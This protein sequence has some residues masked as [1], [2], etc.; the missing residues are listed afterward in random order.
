MGRP[1]LRTLRGAMPTSCMLSTSGRDFLLM[2]QLQVLK[3]A[4]QQKRHLVINQHNQDP[5]QQR[6]HQS[7][8]V[9][10]RCLLT[11]V[12][13]LDRQSLIWLVS[14]VELAATQRVGLSTRKTQHSSTMPSMLLT[15]LKLG[16]SPPLLMTLWGRW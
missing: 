1:L 15:S 6:H 9:A 11:Q 14:T 3:A 16:Y 12:V 5:D 7:K 8:P 13:P 10:E 4:A 2:P